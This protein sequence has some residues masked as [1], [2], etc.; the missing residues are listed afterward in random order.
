MTVFGSLA[1]CAANPSRNVPAG[2]GKTASLPADALVT[3]VFN[4][5]KDFTR[6]GFNRLISEN[7]V[8]SKSDFVNSA[9]KG[10]Y[11][12]PLQ[13]LACSIDSDVKEGIDLRAVAFTW[14]KKTQPFGQTEGTLNSGTAV[15]V[16]KYENGTWRLTQVNGEN[17]FF[18]VK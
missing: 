7:F 9:E 13:E 8:P 2:S 18:T 10:F 17:P 12:S 16:F 3:T 4:S 5:Y 1:G 6:E 15:F 14:E 11:S